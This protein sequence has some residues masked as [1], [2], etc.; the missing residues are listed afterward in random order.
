MESHQEE[1]Y[2][3]GASLR[4]VKVALR[5]REEW[6]SKGPIGCMWLRIDAR[7]RFC[8][9]ICTSH[10][11]CELENP[12]CCDTC[13]NLDAMTIDVETAVLL[14]DLEEEIHMICKQVH[15]EDNVLFLQHSSYGLVQAAQ[16]YYTRLLQC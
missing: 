12:D 1:R 9:F 2:G 15:D 6:D 5:C 16:Q 7:S 3:K 10:Y 14:G 11:G 8:R 4:K 13:M